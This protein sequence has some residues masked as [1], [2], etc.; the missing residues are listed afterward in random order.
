MRKLLSE[1]PVVAPK[2][3]IVSFEVP[4]YLFCKLKGIVF[5]HTG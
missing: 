5:S 3:T 1:D 2:I 4:L